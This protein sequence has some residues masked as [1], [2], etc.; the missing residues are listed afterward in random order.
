MLEIFKATGF[1]KE[2]YFYKLQVQL[3]ITEL[4]ADKVRLI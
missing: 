1:F 4:T 2:W 3:N